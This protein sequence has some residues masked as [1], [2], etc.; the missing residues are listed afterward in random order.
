MNAAVNNARPPPRAPSYYTAT[1]NED[2]DYPTLQG[3]VKVD[4]AIIGGGFT[5]V[6]T[7]VE[8]AERGLKVAIVETHKIGWGASGRNGGQVTGSLSGDEAMR[9]QM[10]RG[11]ARTSTTSSGTCAG[12]GT[13][14]SSSRVAKYGIACDLKHGHLHAA[15]KPSHRT[16]RSFEEAVRRGM[17]DEVTCSTAPGARTCKASCT[18]ARSRTPATCTCTRSTCASAK[19]ARPK[20]GRADL[21]KLRSAGHHP[22]PAPGGGHRPRPGID[23]AR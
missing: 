16:A 18:T 20:P 7:A 15:M 10:R 13:R 1:L 5:G 21:R 4:V 17:G 22:R 3:Q 9:K 19:P 8:L 14:S 23:A 12:A 2:T 6:A 11:S